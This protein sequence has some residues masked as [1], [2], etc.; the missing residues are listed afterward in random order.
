MSKQALNMRK[1]AALAAN[2]R[3]LTLDEHSKN[4]IPHADKLPGL[5]GRESE[6]LSWVAQGK[7][8]SEVAMILGISR[9]TVD[10][11]LSRTYQKLGVETRMAAVMRIIK[12]I[13]IC[14]VCCI[15]SLSHLI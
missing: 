3:R 6:V 4:S 14:V 9:R 12:F 2:Q 10:T 8:N 7:T 15:G 11:L 5:S 1:A 13:K